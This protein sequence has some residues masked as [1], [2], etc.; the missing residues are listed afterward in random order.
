MVK[1]GVLE[2][3]RALQANQPFFSWLQEVWSIFGSV[4]CV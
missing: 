1:L 2:S 3:V 4:V